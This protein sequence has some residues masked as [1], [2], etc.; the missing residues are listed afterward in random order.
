MLLQENV[1][2]YIAPAVGVIFF[3]SLND[4][5]GYIAPAVGTVFSMS[6][7]DPTLIALFFTSALATCDALYCSCKTA[8]LME[9]EEAARRED[10]AE[11][12]SVIAGRSV[13]YRVLFCLY[14]E[15]H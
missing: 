3:M 9:L 11:K 7:N 5:C 10:A 12:V 8:R 1:C 15:M 4:P 6:L 2:G 13:L 14:C